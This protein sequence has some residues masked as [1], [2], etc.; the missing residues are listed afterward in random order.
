V[1]LFQ[2]SARPGDPVGKTFQSAKMM[3]NRRR[4]KALELQERRSR[5]VQQEDAAGKLLLK[6]PH[7]TSLSLEVHETRREGVV[8]DTHHIRRVVI[9]HA[10]AL[11][12]V[13]CSNP[14]CEDGGYD[15]TRE[16]L[17]ALTARQVKFEAEQDCRGRCGPA[18]CGR[19]LRIVA[20]ATYRDVPAES[21]P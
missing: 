14:S 15:V 2:R 4:E 7:L 10:P 21:M 3:L 13:S 12:A 16:I 6:A 11:F 8:G 17:Y 18:D 1:L 20:T 19:H 5:R 9:E